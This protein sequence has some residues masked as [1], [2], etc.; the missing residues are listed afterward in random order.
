MYD[1]TVFLAAAKATGMLKV[2]TFIAAGGGSVSLDV[3]FNQPDELML[4][5]QVQSREYMI[6]YESAAGAALLSGTLVTID[7]VVYRVRAAPRSVRDGFFS[8]AELTKV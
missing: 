1:P 8:T 6:E 4:S 5:D 7:G 2:A 3:G